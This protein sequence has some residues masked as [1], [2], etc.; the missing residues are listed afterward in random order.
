MLKTRQAPAPHQTSAIRE[1]LTTTS[2]WPTRMYCNVERLWARPGSL[3]G[4]CRLV[5]G[6]TPGWIYRRRTALSRD[7]WSLNNQIEEAKDGA[8]SKMTSLL[9]CVVEISC[10]FFK[11]TLFSHRASIF[12]S[13][14]TIVFLGKRS[15]KQDSYWVCFKDVLFDCQLILMYS[16]NLY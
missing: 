4:Q 5:T 9:T 10:I 11:W 13:V 3:A 1:H 14:F 15:T 8:F 6:E 2:A 12:K 7:W 16:T